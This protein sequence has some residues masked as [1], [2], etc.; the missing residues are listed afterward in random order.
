MLNYGLAKHIWDVP[1]TSL[2]PG[3]LKV[4]T[5]KAFLQHHL[6]SADLYLKWN[7]VSANV[8]CAA[9]AA[10][11]SSILLFYLRIFPGRAFKIAVWIAAF[12]VVGYNF[13]CIFADTFSCNPIAKSW[14]VTILSGSCIN[15]PILYFVNAGLGIFTDFVTLLLPL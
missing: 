3:F 15:R 9:T 14:D 10:S 11:K 4:R 8:Y 13:A 12:F 7:L 1:L 6:R 2:S 5:N